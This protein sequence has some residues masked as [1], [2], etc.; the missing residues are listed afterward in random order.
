MK[1]EI[2]LYG[3]LEDNK[4]FLKKIF[5]KALNNDLLKSVRLK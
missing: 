2:E 3:C 1:I 4:A 5:N